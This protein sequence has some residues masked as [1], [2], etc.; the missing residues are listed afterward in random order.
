MEAKELMVGDWVKTDDGNSKIVSLDARHLN[1]EDN[2]YT[3]DEYHVEPIPLTKEI[4][5]K[6]GFCK[7]RDSDMYTISCQQNDICVDL[8]YNEIDICVFGERG[9]DYE[10]C[11][12][13]S[14]IQFKNPIQLHQLQNALRLA[15]L[16]ELAD[17][18]KL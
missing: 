12:S 9:T 17:N 4:L 2:D 7:Y 10:E 6:N 13:S 14:E 5:E 11:E 3:Y 16:N 1:V 18:L 8:K 15:G